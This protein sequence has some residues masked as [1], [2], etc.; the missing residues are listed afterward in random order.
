MLVAD[1]IKTLNSVAPESLAGSWDNVG[2]LVGD[3]SLEFKGPVFLTLDLTDPVID[4]AI[5]CRAGFVI[6]YHPPLFHAAK[7]YTQTD[8]AGRTI[9]KLLHAGVAGI[10]SPHSALDAAPGGL[11]DWLIERAAQNPSPQAVTNRRALEPVSSGGAMKLV[12]FVP[13]DHAGA[14][15]EALHRA[16]AGIIGDYD[17]CT[18]ASSGEGTF[19][20]NASTNPAV[21]EPGRLERV[22]E[23]RLETVVPPSRVGAVVEAIR[24]AHPYEEPAFDLYRTERHPDPSIGAGRVGD[25][26]RPLTAH[27]IAKHL[28]R[29]LNIAGVRLALPDGWDPIQPLTRI[30]CCPG[31]GSSLVD[32]AINQG[33]QLFIT[34]EM[35]H[36]ELLS[37]T[38]QGLAIAL[39]G[40]TNTERPYIGLYAE[41]I[42]GETGLEVVVS[43]R[44]R[45]PWEWVD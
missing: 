1:L 4:E 15:R 20:G 12:V 5:A 40:H 6:A 27:T 37:A 35:R 38:E 43:E 44:D 21:G 34:G 31:A 22:P 2:L 29:N 13:E 24:E 33:A 16:G 14:L 45:C 39:A 28:S 30:A 41:R 19:R 17:H 32:G 7:R 36:H 11:N 8:R 42:K 10:Y 3:S 26:A 9:T 23:L 18:Y 25:L